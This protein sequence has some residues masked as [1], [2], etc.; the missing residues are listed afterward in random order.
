MRFGSH[1][2]VVY[3]TYSIYS[4][5][6]VFIILDWE[7]LLS[8]TYSSGIFV[9]TYHPLEVVDGSFGKFLGSRDSDQRSADFGDYSLLPAV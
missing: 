9:R 5:K 6:K 3:F 7:V 2:C 4:H 8:K 1:F